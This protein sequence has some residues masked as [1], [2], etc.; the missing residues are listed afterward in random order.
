[1]ESKRSG[2]ETVRAGREAGLL[3][4]LSLRPSSQVEDWAGGADQLQRATPRRGGTVALL[5]ALALTAV[6]LRALSERTGEATHLAKASPSPTIS[7]AHPAVS[8]AH[9]AV[10]V[11]HPAVSVA[12]PAGD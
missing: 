2:E 6:A 5:C 9:P 3:S 11:A 10:S 8:V 4:R 7:V 12:H 1:M